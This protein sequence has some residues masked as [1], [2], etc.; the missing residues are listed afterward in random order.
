MG[1]ARATWE[2]LLK[3]GQEKNL[4]SKGK[5]SDQGWRTVGDFINVEYDRSTMTWRA[6]D[7]AQ[8]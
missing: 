4:C 1:M 2:A 6:I 5:I 8:V 7:L 3:Y